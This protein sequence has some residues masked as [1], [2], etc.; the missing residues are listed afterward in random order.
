MMSLSLSRKVSIAAAAVAT[1]AAL[2]LA[3]CSSSGSEQGYPTLP[4]AAVP[5]A[6]LEWGQTG[7]IRA[8]SVSTK[9]LFV[10]EFV[11]SAKSIVQIFQ[12]GTFK[13][14]GQIS[15]GINSPVGLWVDSHGLYVANNLAPTITQYSYLT[16]APFTYKAGIGAPM[17]VTTD[18]LGDIFE[19]DYDGYVNEYYQQANF[20]VVKCPVV[21]G[22]P[23]GVAHGTTRGVVFVAYVNSAGVGHILEFTDFDSCKSKVLGVKLGGTGEIAVDK[24]DDIIVTE[25]NKNAVDILKPPY[26][27]VSGHLGSGW[28]NPAD[29]KI[30]AANTR[31]WVLEDIFLKE[32][33]YPS[34]KVVGS[35]ELFNIATGGAV[36][37]S[38]YVP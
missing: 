20:V 4:T 3:G 33:D 17:A 10:G 11:S 23:T 8:D 19:A 36:D 27:T 30:N 7:G 35:L 28:E 1:S 5:P 34:G 6:L 13:K 37:G 32:V 2:F 15:K 26:T 38:N 29:V 18:R 9:D 31:A 12:N 21:G 24:Q 22:T 16:S 14:L 25:P